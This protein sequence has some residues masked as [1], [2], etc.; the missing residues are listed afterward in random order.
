MSLFYALKVSANQGCNFVK[1]V[2]STCFL[3]LGVLTSVTNAVAAP[4]SGIPADNE[5]VPSSTLNANVAVFAAKVASDVYDVNGKHNVWLTQNNFVTA[6]LIND[7]STVLTVMGSLQAVVAHKV[8]NSGKNLYVV[9]FRGTEHNT[10]D[11]GV[12]FRFLGTSWKAIDYSVPSSPIVYKGMVH[13]GF[14]QAAVAMSGQEKSINISGLTFD[15]VIRNASKYPSPSNGDLFL[16]VGHSLGGAVATLYATRLIDAGIPATNVMTYTFGA[17]AIGD[18]DFIKN[19]DSLTGLNLHRIRNFTDPVPFSTEL[20]LGQFSNEHVFSGNRMLRSDEWFTYRPA[21]NFDGHSMST[22][23]DNLQGYPSILSPAA[24]AINS[25]TAVQKFCTIDGETE[26]LIQCNGDAACELSKSIC[27]ASYD[28][29]ASLL[30]HKILLQKVYSLAADMMIR[31]NSYLIKKGLVNKTSVITQL[32]GTKVGV[33]LKNKMVKNQV[34]ITE[35]VTLPLDVAYSVMVDYLLNNE[36]NYGAVRAWKTTVGLVPFQ[37][38]VQPFA[39]STNED[40]KTVFNWWSQLAY[41]NMKGWILAGITGNPLLAA[42]ETV[43]G[44]M[45]VLKD[46]SVQTYG[47]T[48]NAL[49]ASSALLLSQ[50]YGEVLSLRR[51][52]E[53][54]YYQAKGASAKQ[55]VFSSFDIKCSALTLSGIAKA[56]ALLTRTVVDKNRTIRGYCDSA[57]KE[58]ETVDSNRVKALQSIVTIGDKQA[59]GAFVSYFY[60]QDEYSMYMGYF[61]SKNYDYSLFPDAGLNTQIS[62][63]LVRANTYRLPLDP[64]SGG[65]RFRAELPVSKQYATY[66]SFMG[67]QVVVGKILHLADD[68]AYT[69]LLK[70]AKSKTVNLPNASSSISRAELATIVVASFGLEGKV[71]AAL[72]TDFR[73]E[74]LKDPLWTYEAIILRELEVVSP[75]KSFEPTRKASRFETLIILNNT[76]DILTCLQKGCGLLDVAGKVY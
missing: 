26:T 47:A 48:K 68:N 3:V 20:N 38:D 56:S 61:N 55:A 40:I 10:L 19:Y 50:K 31:L 43:V 64:Y 9:A 27:I 30:T 37:T 60:P 46:V 65:T 12:N 58:M 44:N 54:S 67:A 1:V 17:P 8:L 6:P 71:S 72:K 25:L 35:F 76:M 39:R 74:A 59:F 34:S 52:V 28:E 73:N 49:T 53:K 16:I 29:A 36:V 45:L 13:A 2:V 63:V 15:Q 5:F 18:A 41:N 7:P 21:I 11:W 42:K 22:Y 66:L 32:V 33:K 69:N 57:K 70:I 23:I 4:I 62:K 24:I 14:Y 75:L 51:D